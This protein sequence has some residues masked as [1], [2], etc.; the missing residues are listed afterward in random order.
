METRQTCTPE[1]F[2]WRPIIG[3]MGHS[4]DTSCQLQFWEKI[5]SFFTQHI[6]LWGFLCI[7]VCD[8]KKKLRKQGIHTHMSNSHEGQSLTSWINHLDT[9]GQSHFWEKITSFHTQHIGLRVFCRIFVCDAMERKNSG[10][11]VNMYIWI[12]F[13]K[14]NCWIHEQPSRHL[15]LITLWRKNSKF[16]YTTH[17]TL[18]ILIDILCPMERKVAKIR[19]I[20]TFMYFA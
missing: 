19:E 15:R 5:T 2:S 11:K 13:M 8:G 18:S 17:R 14:A 6:G 16:P 4:S 7:L 3:F 12:L 1:Y 10:N 9:Y 20:Y